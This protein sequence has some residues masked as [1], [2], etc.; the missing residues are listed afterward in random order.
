MEQCD[1]PMYQRQVEHLAECVR[2]GRQPRP[3]GAEGLLIQNRL[4]NFTS[5]KGS[6]VH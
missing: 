5:H 2:E 1:W 6:G 4:C 3:G